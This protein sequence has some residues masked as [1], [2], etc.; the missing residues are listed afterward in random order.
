MKTPDDGSTQHMVGVALSR[1]ASGLLGLRKIMRGW[2]RCKLR[3]SR[4]V[5]LGIRT[6]FGRRVS[7]MPSVLLQV[8]RGSD[9]PACTGLSMFFSCSR[10]AWCPSMCEAWFSSGRLL[11]ACHF[12]LVKPRL[13]PGPPT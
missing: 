2:W 12:N 13:R 9:L 6:L 3:C 8:H 11:E 7:G 5:G 1:R 10:A 4:P